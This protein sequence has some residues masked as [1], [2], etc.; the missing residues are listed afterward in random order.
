MLKRA[1][2]ILLAVS[3]ALIWLI[4]SWQVATAAEY[5]PQIECVIFGSATSNALQITREDLQPVRQ[6]QFQYSEIA[7][8]NQAIAPEVAQQ[9]GTN[10]DLLRV[11]AM[12]LL[13]LALV[14]IALSAM[15]MTAHKYNQRLNREMPQ[16]V[17]TQ[18]R[19]LLQVIEDSV[20]AIIHQAMD[21]DRIT[22]QNRVVEIGLL[23][24]ERTGNGGV[25]L[26]LNAD[27]AFEPD[28][29]GKLF[30]Q[31]QTWRIE[32]DRWGRINKMSQD[33]VPRY[34]TI[35]TILVSEITDVGNG[36]ENGKGQL[37]P[38]KNGH[39]L[40]SG[41]NGGGDGYTTRSDT[42]ISITSR[43]SYLSR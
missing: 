15:F 25:N 28:S 31:L 42:C 2:L 11:I 35:E 43:R 32:A 4:T 39:L 26:K 23:E 20:K 29:N 34:V 7:E 22:G 18:E 3:F 37:E 30:R 40:P 13:V 10:P 17:Y 5:A 9:A 1:F 19:H 27:I 38:P 8:I 16:P 24:F 36:R 14:A 6:N 41:E 12:I 33:G 21:R